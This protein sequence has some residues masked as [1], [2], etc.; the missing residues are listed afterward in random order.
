MWETPI[1]LQVGAPSVRGVAQKMLKRT[2]FYISSSIAVYMLAR[3][4]K[5]RTGNITQIWIMGGEIAR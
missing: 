5:A 2:V 4:K 1:R 3:A